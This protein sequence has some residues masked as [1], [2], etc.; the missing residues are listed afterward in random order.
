[1]SSSS[2]PALPGR[3]ADTMGLLV[4]L[5]RVVLLLVVLLRLVLFLLLVLRRR[6]GRAVEAAGAERRSG[7]CRFQ[8]WSAGLGFAR[9]ADRRGGEAAAFAGVVDVG[10]FV[11]IGRNQLVPGDEEDVPAGRAGVDEG[12]A[13]G[14]G[15]ARDQLDSPALPLVDVGLAV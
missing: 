6:V 11:L 4:L 14:A 10:V 5:L 2:S 7:R 12:R 13:V 15:P 8:R 9:R 1:A 3:A